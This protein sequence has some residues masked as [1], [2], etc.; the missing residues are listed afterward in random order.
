MAVFEPDPVHLRQQIASIAGQ[1]LAPSRLVAVIADTVSEPE[2][3][4]AAAAAGIEPVIVMPDAPLDAVRAF[5]TGLGRA[6]ELTSDTPDALIALSDQDDVWHPDRLS[7]GA[8]RLNESGADLVHS[9]ARLIDGAGADLHPSMFALERREPRPGLRG[10]L[11]RNTVT[12]MTVLMRRGLV[13]LALPFPP[14]SGLHFYHDLWLALVAE[15]TGGIARIDR[16]LVD[17]RQHGGNAIGAVDR[18]KG[19]LGRILRRIR[20]PRFGKEWVRVQAGPYALSRYLAAALD[21]R[22]RDARGEAPAAGGLKQ[23]RPYLGARGG[24]WRHLGA[25]S[26]YALRLRPDLAVI[27]L[28]HTAMALVRQGWVLLNALGQGAAQ[29]RHDFDG[30]L[31]SLSPGVMPP[32]FAEA[33][34][35]QAPQSFSK[36]V[37]PRTRLRVPVR[38]EAPEPAFVV[39]VPSLNPSEAYAGIATALD[40]GLGIAG[41]GHRVRFV[42]TD[43]AVMSHEVSRRF[44]EGRI[45][46]DARAQTGSRI[47][48]HCA[49]RGERSEGALF[50]NPD[51]RLMATAWWTAHIARDLIAEQALTRQDFVYLLQDF[52]PNF[53]PW[54]ADYAEAWKSYGFRFRPVFNTTLLR[55]YFAG[56]GFGFAADAPAFRPSIAL[57]RYAGT[58]RPEREAGRPR[59]LVVYGR[60]GVARN[61]FPTVITA[62]SAFIET[63]G[64]GPA[65]LEAVSVGQRHGPVSL[66]NGI[67]LQGLGK[68]PWDDYPAFLLGCDLGVSL[69]LSPHPSHPPLEMAASGVRVVTNRFGPKDLSHLS[70]AILSA[71]PDAGSVAEALGRAWTAPPVTAAERRVALEALGQ[72]LG[73]VIDLL[74]SELALSEPIT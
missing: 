23:L 67:V 28:G 6:L 3:R 39:L 43:L 46:A 14:Q 71:A 52:E 36:I 72:P 12:G 38:L 11:Y 20:R 13:E 66:P 4:E 50:L 26:G 64:L 16:P 10:L 9:D 47:S 53:Y 2:V 1:D 19:A 62:L 65:Q 22:I 27:A 63:H 7:A 57:D 24:F 44:L 31:F 29:W 69:M 5:E 40:I 61:M 60:P 41:R 56:Q 54:G 25:T 35:S 58:E 32:R 68:L 49:V 55:D 45:R 21:D 8:G 73:E 37:D 30:K 59:R 15:A 33:E 34:V 48:L 74:A 51:D 42:A 70:G 17:Y 18:R